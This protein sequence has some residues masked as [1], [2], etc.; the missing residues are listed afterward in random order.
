MQLFHFVHQQKILK[1]ISSFSRWQLKSL[2]TK[3]TLVVRS[4]EAGIRLLPFH[5]SKLAIV[6]YFLSKLNLQN[7]DVK[8]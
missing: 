6:T 1:Q 4:D 3:E 5:F 8:M 7:I 2:V